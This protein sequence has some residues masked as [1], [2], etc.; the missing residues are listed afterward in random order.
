MTLDVL[1]AT[2]ATGI[3]AVDDGAPWV[4]VS[5]LGCRIRESVNHRDT[6]G[7]EEDAEKIC[8]EFSSDLCVSVSL[9]LHLSL[10]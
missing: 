8:I 2:A 9:W 4:G 5:S 1:S 3:V 10:R 6:E 7:T